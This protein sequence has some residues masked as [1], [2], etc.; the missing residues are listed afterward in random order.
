MESWPALLGAVIC[1]SSVTIGFVSV[2]IQFFLNVF[3]LI[4]MWRHRNDEFAAEFQSAKAFLRN[5]NPL[6]LFH[7]SKELPTK[8]ENTT[9]PERERSVGK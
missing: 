2:A 7:Y 1:I 4:G 6:A 5:P 3:Q 9:G 8:Q